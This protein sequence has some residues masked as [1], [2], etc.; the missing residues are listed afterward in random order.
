[1][2][3]IVRII[4]QGIF[5][6]RSYWDRTDTSRFNNGYNCKWASGTFLVAALFISILYAFYT[7]FR[8]PG[9][10]SINYYQV[11]YL[12]GFYRRALLG[13]FLTPFGC[14]RF[15]YFFIQKLQFAILFSALLLFVYF[16]IKKRESLTLS[17]FFLSAAGGYFFHEVGYIEQFLWIVAAMAIVAIDKN[18]YYLAALLLCLSVMA[19]EMAV[20]M[21]LPIALAYVVIRQQLSML[22]LIKIF[23]LPVMMF[24]LI[25]TSFQVVP[26][27][28]INRYFEKIAGCGTTTIRADYFD[29]FVNH[30]EQR[31]SLYYSFEQLYSGILPLLVLAAYLAFSIRK[32]LNL[33]VYQ[34][35]IILGCCLSPLLLGLFGWDASRW[36]FLALTQIIIIKLIASSNILEHSTAYKKDRV[37]FFAALI[38]AGV[39]L[40]LTYFDDVLPREVSFHH[41]ATFKDYVVN[42][43]SNIPIP[44]Q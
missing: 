13:T 1:M 37:L 2:N 21:V 42:Q 18:H 43:I 31:A 29:I 14:L 30:F 39:I 24:L 34:M 22:N 7:G 6:I 35:F 40:Q 23:A 9:L 3:Q 16:G 41:V 32:S 33:N 17:I 38:V 19:H 15:D 11:G 27:E 36:I 28:T 10:W 12:D 8:T 4:Q 26:D 25:F 20:F 44:N 5:H